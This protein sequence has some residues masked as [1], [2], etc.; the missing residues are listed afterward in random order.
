MVDSFADAPGS[1][2]ARGFAWIFPYMGVLAL[3]CNLGAA[4]GVRQLG[5]DIEISL[6]RPNFPLTELQSLRYNRPLLSG[7]RHAHL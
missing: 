7:G 6:S 5:L 1:R 2:C 3:G 4:F